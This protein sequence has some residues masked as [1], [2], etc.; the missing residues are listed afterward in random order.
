MH[1][2]KMPQDVKTVPDEMG[3]VTS[4]IIGQKIYQRVETA[5]TQ[6]ATVGRPHTPKIDQAGLYRL[7]NPGTGKDQGREDGR[8]Q[9]T[10]DVI[11]FIVRLGLNYGPRSGG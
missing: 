8:K 7:S 5:G 9:D 2:V 10:V 6:A 3:Q 4:E 1:L 11:E